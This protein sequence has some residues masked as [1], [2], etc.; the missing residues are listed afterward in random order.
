MLRNLKPTYPFFEA[1]VA[2]LKLTSYDDLKV[3]KSV[4]H[5]D[6]DNYTAEELHDINR[7]LESKQRD[8]FI[9]LAK[10]ERKKRQGQNRAE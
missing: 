1:M 10:D 6:K 3:L 4:I 7:V 2:I 5:D 9:E 8:I